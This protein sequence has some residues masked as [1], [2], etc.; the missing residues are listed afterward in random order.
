M[1][2]KITNEDGEVQTVVD[3]D[4]AGAAWDEATDWDGRNH[5]SRNTGSQWDHETL[6]LSRKGHYYIVSESQWQGSLPSARFV[7]DQEAAQWLALNDQDMPAELVA[8]GIE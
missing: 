2:M 8:E 6:Y 7:S 4:K 3:T 5:I 1:K